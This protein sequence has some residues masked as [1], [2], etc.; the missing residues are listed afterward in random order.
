MALLGTIRTLHIVVILWSMLAAAQ[1][2]TDGWL[3]YA[4]AEHEHKIITRFE[5][6]WQNMDA[7]KSVSTAF[8]S[9]WIGIGTSDRLNIIQ[10]VNPWIGSEWQSYIEYFQ[11]VPE[12]NKNSL[13]HV[14]YPGD[15]FHSLIEYKE[16]HF[17]INGSNVT[18]PYYHV[19]HS[20][21]TQH[22]TIE[23][24]VPVQ[25]I[26]ETLKMDEMAHKQYT[27]VYFAFST[28]NVSMDCGAYPD[29]GSIRFYNISMWFDHKLIKYPIWKTSFYND[30]CHNRAALDP[31]RDNDT[32]IISWNQT[33]SN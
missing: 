21:L 18:T 29:G 11:W 27:S 8:F 30:S 20:D 1:D 12:R 23:N 10:C 33:T 28:Q 3:G 17:N 4:R 16:S 24:R 19:R 13:S 9:P 6:Y 32:V 26:N 2:P 14:T 7:P 15:T 25:G 31:A 5:V 22:W